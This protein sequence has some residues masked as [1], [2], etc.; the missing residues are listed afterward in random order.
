MFTE[1]EI[2][3][4]ERYRDNYSK[5]AHNK[6]ADIYQVYTGVKVNCGC[7]KAQ[8]YAFITMFYEWYEENS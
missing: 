8:R 4:I 6:L 7:K 3:T 1:A 2:E 5:L